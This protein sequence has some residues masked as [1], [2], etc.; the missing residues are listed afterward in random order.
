MARSPSDNRRTQRV[1]IAIPV[2]VYGNEASATPLKEMTQTMVV[3]AT[4]GLI[5]LASNVV[6]GQKLILVNIKSLEEI[7][8]TVATLR[9]DTNG[10]AQVG[11]VFD[12]PSP[13]FWGLAFPP[14]DWDPADRKRPQQTLHPK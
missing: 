11:I 6:I 4:G 1:L 8:C 3:N 9:D 7:R 13:R 12:Q 5:L 10:K 14:E 2:L